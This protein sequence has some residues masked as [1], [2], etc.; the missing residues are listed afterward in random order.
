M[1]HIDIVFCPSS[2][3]VPNPEN[4]KNINFPPWGHGNIWIDV[5]QPIWVSE[6]LKCLFRSNWPKCSWST[7]G[8][9]KVKDGQNQ[10]KTTFFMLLHQTR[11]TQRFSL[12]LIRG[13]LLRAIKTIILIR[14]SEQV[15]PSFIEK[16]IEFPF[17]RLFMGQNRS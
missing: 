17:Q 6:N 2:I 1:R 10:L 4:T 11:A 7:L 14:L 12:T 16:I 5:T 8:W 13:W 3:C 9:P 15:G